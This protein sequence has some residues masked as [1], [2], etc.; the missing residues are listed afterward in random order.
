MKKTILS[1][2]TI[3]FSLSANANESFPS[4][5]ICDSAY[6]PIHSEKGDRL[7]L[8]IQTG[9]LA[10]KSIDSNGKTVSFSGGGKINDMTFN[11]DSFD[12]KELV[13]VS[14]ETIDAKY[15]C[16]TTTLPD[17]NKTTFNQQLVLKKKNS[18]TFEGYLR[19]FESGSLGYS[20]Y[21][22]NCK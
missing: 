7:K 20:I 8:F 5:L 2:A 11:S 12:C 4:S 9:P 3:I 1:I 10:I 18:S 16:E 14:N 19:N 22:W 6:S 15:F 17:A 13:L 21:L